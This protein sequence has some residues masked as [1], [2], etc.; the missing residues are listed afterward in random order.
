[1]DFE[2]PFTHVTRLEAIKLL[3]AGTYSKDIKPFQIDDKSAFFNG[4]IFQD[5][6]IKYFLSFENL[7]YS[8]IYI[9]IS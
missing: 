1:M 7:D 5:I 3:L 8:I 4:L 9:F 2:K 6:F